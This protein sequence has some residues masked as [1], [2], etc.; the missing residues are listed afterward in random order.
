MYFFIYTQKWIPAAREQWVLVITNIEPHMQSLTKKTK[1]VYVQ[2][3]DAL[4]PH[5]I[6]IKEVVVPHFQV[7]FFS[8]FLNFT[9]SMIKMCPN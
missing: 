7:C 8:F 6:K 5:V 1:E 9:F 4:T 3:K 2:S